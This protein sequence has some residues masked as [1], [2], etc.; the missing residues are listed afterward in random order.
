MQANY[1][2]E[3]G[4]N[5]IL[6]KQLNEKY[7]I[8][9]KDV[10]ACLTSSGDI[11]HGVSG[12]DLI[13]KLRSKQ[14]ASIV[15]IIIKKIE[16]KGIENINSLLQSYILLFMNRI[17]LAQQRKYELIVYHFLE[18]FYTSSIAIRKNDNFQ[19]RL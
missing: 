19:H 2:K 17:F 12:H 8:N 4:A 7:R 3:F 9:K 5:P 13:L 16:E 15:D 14:N 11:R 1:F 18:K 10:F 6:Q